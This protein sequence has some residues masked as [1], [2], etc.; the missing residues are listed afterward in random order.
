MKGGKVNV[1]GH[2]THR[3]TQMN[4]CLVRFG[5][6]GWSV[7]IVG[8]DRKLKMGFSFLIYQEDCPTMIYCCETCPH[9]NVLLPK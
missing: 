4:A 7:C 5:L 3:H 1:V 9:F 8:I 2:T 6:L